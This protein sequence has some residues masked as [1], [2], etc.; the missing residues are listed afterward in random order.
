MKVKVKVEK[1]KPREVVTALVCPDCRGT[2]LS[3]EGGYITGRKYH[4][5]DCHAAK[6]G[7]SAVATLMRG[8]PR[9]LVH[10]TVEHL[11]AVRY[12]MPPWSGTPQEA[13]VLTD[14]LMSITPERPKGMLPELP[15]LEAN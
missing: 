13:E 12:F 3:F 8:Q 7:Y 1:R 4:C 11:D 2:N 5:N 6:Q 15:P 9:S 14:Y 10:E